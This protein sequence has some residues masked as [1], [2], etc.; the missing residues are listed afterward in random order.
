MPVTQWARADQYL[1]ITV[2]ADQMTW[3]I[4]VYTNNKAAD[5]NP[6]FET[7][8]QPGL[9]GSNPAGLVDSQN[10]AKRLPVAWAVQAST[11]PVPAPVPADPE[12][13]LADTNSFQWHYMADAQTPTIPQED[14]IAFTPGHLNNVVLYNLGIHYGQDIDEFGTEWPPA[15]IYL[16]ANFSKAIASHYRTNKIV[17]E[18]FTP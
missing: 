11:Y 2:D 9:P 5:A 13:G 14:T 18:F 6:K 3:G 4:Q 7:T 10:H 15:R 17:V 8:V 1:D 12:A 16:Q